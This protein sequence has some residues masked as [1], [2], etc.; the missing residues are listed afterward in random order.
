M[1]II[2]ASVSGVR[3]LTSDTIEFHPQG[4]VFFG[5]NGS[6]KTSVLEALHLLAM[7]RSFRSHSLRPVIHHDAQSCMVTAK[8]EKAGLVQHMG[9]E[10]TRSGDST[11]RLNGKNVASLS[12][13]AELLPLVL[14]DTEGLELIFGSPDNRRRYLDGTL[15]H[16]EHLFLEVWRRYQRTL[17]QRNAGLRRGI[18]ASDDAWLAD[19]AR[20]GD[21]L[22]ETRRSLALRLAAAFKDVAG[23]LSPSLCNID[24]VFKQG[25]DERVQLID[26][27][28]GSVESDHQRGFTQ[29]G[30]HRADL[31]LRLDGRSAA[32]NLSRGQAKLAVAALRLAQGV[33]LAE[34]QGVPPVYLVD[35]ITAELDENHAAKVCEILVSQGGQ[36]FIAAVESGEVARF[37]PERAFKMFHVEQG[38]I[39][40]LT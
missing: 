22:T 4:N 34:S 25:W 15:F 32:D 10:R 36:V 19:L 6:G 12:S 16:V 33:V 40:A 7:G 35:D 23:R 1:R 13:L 30:P 14:L 31:R 37:W 18:M 38:T 28:V 24:L 3:N 26:A 39:K 11:L 8:V 2:S 27:L 17:K 21:A 9:M 5:L 20:A 29:L